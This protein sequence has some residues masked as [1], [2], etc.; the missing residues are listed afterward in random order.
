MV[1][2][3]NG[4]YLPKERVA[5]SPD[6]RGFLFGDGVYEATPSYQGRFLALDRHLARLQ[7]GLEG[8]RIKGVRAATLEPVHHELLVRNGLEKSRALVY[9]QITRGAAKRRHAFPEPAVPPT[10][11]ATVSKVEPKFD[12]AVGVAVITTPDL[13]WG[14]CDLKTVNLLPNCLANQQAQEAGAFEAIFVRAGRAT[15]GT[16]TSLFWVQSGV[17]ATHPNGPEILPSVTRALLLEL[18]AANGVPV[19]ERVIGID[20]LRRA[21]EVLL[22]GS[23]TEV[24]PVVRIDSAP[25]ADGR[26]GPVT[27]RLQQLYSA[28]IN[29]R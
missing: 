15:E 4:E 3:F 18:C 22:T 7:R 14:R 9:V 21:D 17:L 19:E 11:Y 27:R 26:P 10:V 16:H 20:D 13:R 29:P 6:D 2:Y 25:V 1:V 12:P 8:L 5:I 28:L 23:T 24:A